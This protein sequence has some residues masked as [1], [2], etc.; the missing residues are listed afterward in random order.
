MQKGTQQRALLHY[1]NFLYKQL[2]INTWLFY[3][4]IEEILGKFSVGK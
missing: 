4:R 3:L 2:R 1:N